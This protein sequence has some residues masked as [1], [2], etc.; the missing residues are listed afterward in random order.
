MNGFLQDLRYAVRQFLKTPGL[1]LIV[2]IT[3]ALGDQWGAD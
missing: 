2:V 3:I 1:T